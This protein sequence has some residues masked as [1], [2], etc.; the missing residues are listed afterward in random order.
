MSPT[1]IPGVPGYW[2]SE[3]GEIISG[4]KTLTPQFTPDGYAYVM[5]R[6]K[7]LRVAHAVLLAFSGPRPVGSEARHL[8]DDKTDNRALNLA[9]GTRLENAADSIRNG[10]QARGEQKGTAKL[11][12]AQV[13]ELREMIDRPSL[14]ALAAQYGVS[15]TEI[16]RVIN[17]TKWGHISG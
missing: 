14:R 5:I 13:R 16:R 3:D 11:S 6:R 1:G 10:H 12:E 2:V 8:N 7:R 15:H 9:W 4:R 17:G